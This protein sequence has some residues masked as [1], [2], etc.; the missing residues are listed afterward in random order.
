MDEGQDGDADGLGLGGEAGE[1][2]EEQGKRAEDLSLD[3]LIA[4]LPR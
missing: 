1:E 4:E 2:E 3:P